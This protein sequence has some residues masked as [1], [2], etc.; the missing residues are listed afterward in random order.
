MQSPSN[1]SSLQCKAPASCPLKFLESSLKVLFNPG[2]EISNMKVKSKSS[3]ANRKPQ[4]SISISQSQISDI[5][6]IVKSRTS[7]ARSQNAD[8]NL[9]SQSQISH[10]HCKSQTLNP[11]SHLEAD[12]LHYSNTLTTYRYKTD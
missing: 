7:N 5:N 2:S 9:K 1:F 8:L 12:L 10:S 4:I 6:L 11:K 3:P